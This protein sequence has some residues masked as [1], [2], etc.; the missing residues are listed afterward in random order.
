MTTD[1]TLVNSAQT[2][3][4]GQSRGGDRSAAI[5]DGLRRTKAFEVD[6]LIGDSMPSINGVLTAGGGK[7]PISGQTAKE[8]VF[9]YGTFVCVPLDE[10]IPPFGARWK[11]YA[12]KDL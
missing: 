1:L 3:A 2:C 4:E 5:I 11:V 8:M 6:S 9:S 7:L 10:L 12:V